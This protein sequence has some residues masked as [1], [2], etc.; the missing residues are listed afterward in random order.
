MFYNE[1]GIDLAKEKIDNWQE[2]AS[3]DIVGMVVKKGSPVLTGRASRP[4]F[5]HI[6]QNSAFGNLNLELEEFT[7]Y[8][9]STPKWFSFAICWMS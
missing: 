6:F 2:I 9:L 7:P 4:S 3:P 1:E 5:A 8:S